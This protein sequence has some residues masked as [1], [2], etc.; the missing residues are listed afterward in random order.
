MATLPARANV[1][2]IGA[3]IV[4]NS[5]AF[6]LAKQGWKDIVLIEKGTLPGPSVSPPDD[7]AAVTTTAPRPASAN[8][9]LIV[10]VVLL[11]A[12]L[13]LFLLRWGAR[14]LTDG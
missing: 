13:G 14:R 1:V 8:G 6:H 4:G 12:G 9:L 2:V 7:T 10:S 5:M 3:G 11:I